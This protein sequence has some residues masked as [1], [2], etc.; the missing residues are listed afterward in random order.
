MTPHPVIVNKGRLNFIHKHVSGYAYTRPDDTCR[1]DIHSIFVQLHDTP[2]L[3]APS[4]RAN[5]IC[6]CNPGLWT[7]LCPRIPSTCLMYSNNR[8]TNK[9]RSGLSTKYSAP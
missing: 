8:F 4:S 2:L 3:L 5:G 7:H 9:L 6:N 1:T